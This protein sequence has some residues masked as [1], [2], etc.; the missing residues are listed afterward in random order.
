MSIR[1]LLIFLALLGFGFLVFLILSPPPPPPTPPAPPEPAADYG[2]APDG[3]LGMD[4]GYYAP[5]PGP[6]PGVMIYDNAG[7]AAQFP[8]VGTDPEPG[9]FMLDVEQF[10]IGPFRQ[11]PTFG[12]TPVFFAG[13]VPSVEAGATDPADPDG[14]ANLNPPLPVATKA[15]CD[16]ENASHDPATTGCDP[17]PP[18]AINMNGVLVIWITSRV[19]AFFITRVWTA[20]GAMTEGIAYWN[21]L[22]DLVRDG[23]WGTAAGS[24]VDEWVAR[25]EV[26]PLVPGT[27][28]VLVTQPF[29]WPTSG[30]F[31]RLIFP[32]WARNMV[33]SES[34]LDAVGTSNWDGQGP[35]SGFT[36]GE[37]EDYFIEWRPIGQ[38]LPTPAPSPGPDV[39]GG[40]GKTIAE[41]A[42]IIQLPAISCPE[43]VAPRSSARCEVELGENDS[44]L[45]LCRGDSAT[46][47]VADEAVL[48]GQQ[49]EAQLCSSLGAGATITATPGMVTLEVGS[50]PEGAVIS[51]VVLPNEDS[52]RGSGAMAITSGAQVTIKAPP[53]LRNSG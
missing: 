48:V 4:T 17:V 25:D 31:G 45:V 28:R 7:I 44:I 11:G 16:K 2:D 29:P 18:Y 23:E 27:S 51:L 47:V 30:P 38:I 41:D 43:T 22:F 20:P 32:V 34:V 33:S 37:V 6:L 52:L 46:A 3:D 39:G 5:F 50:A 26:F 1:N 10:W 21:M 19:N 53:T 12:A 15:D 42:D 9:P 8:T 35:A 14:P 24:A 36:Q 40:D 49:A 13:D